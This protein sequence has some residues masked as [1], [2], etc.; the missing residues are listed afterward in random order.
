M[1]SSFT[2]RRNA[3]GIAITSVINNAGFGTWGRF[4]DED[5]DR[6]RQ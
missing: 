4:H 6:L 3:G 1:E 2:R 5:P